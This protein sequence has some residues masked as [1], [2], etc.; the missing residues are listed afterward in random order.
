MNIVINLKKNTFKSKKMNSILKKQFYC[1]LLYR[2][3]IP[4]RTA[5][6]KSISCISA[7]IK[8]MQFF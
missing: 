1:A 2:L 8:S 5:V 7:N 3:K 4:S 6:D